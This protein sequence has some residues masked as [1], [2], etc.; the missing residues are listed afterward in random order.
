MY[1]AHTSTLPFKDNRL[2]S[3]VPTPYLSPYLQSISLQ[4]EVGPEPYP[5]DADGSVTPAEGPWQGDATHPSTQSQTFALIKIDLGTCYFFVP[6]NRLLHCQYIK[7]AGHKD[8]DIIDVYRDLR[9]NTASKGESTQGWIPKPTEQGLQSEDIE[10]RGQG[11]TLPDRSLDRKSLRTLSVHLHQRLQV[12]VQHAV[13][14]AELRLES[15]G[16][17]NRRQEPIVHP[18]EGL[19]LI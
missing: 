15:G 18:I 19:G 11:E 6:P 1:T 14:F 9:A 8:S 16:L 2:R 3:Q 10:K 17:Q 13:P 7:S 5:E 12:V 4:L